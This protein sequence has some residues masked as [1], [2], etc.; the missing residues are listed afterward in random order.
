MTYTNHNQ[1][2]GKWV[3]LRLHYFHII[4]PFSISMGRKSK[5]KSPSHPEVTLK[6]QTRN[7]AFIQCTQDPFFGD[8]FF[9]AKLHKPILP[10]IALVQ[11]AG[12]VVLAIPSDFL[13]PGNG[14]TTKHIALYTLYNP[15]ISTPS[16]KR[17]LSFGCVQRSG[18]VWA[19]D[20][21]WHSVW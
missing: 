14:G 12:Q 17:P 21:L 2:N 20:C 8:A 7:P 18:Q 13:F 6:L 19:L 4:R 1:G 3:C 5:F 10:I 16:V 11:D 15:Y 9:L